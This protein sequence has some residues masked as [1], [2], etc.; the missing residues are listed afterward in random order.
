[1]CGEVLISCVSL[2]LISF[3]VLIPLL[4][5]FFL[6]ILPFLFIFHCTY[7]CSAIS[8]MSVLD[9]ATGDL[10]CSSVTEEDGKALAA[11]S[12]Y[13]LYAVTFCWNAKLVKVGVC[14]NEEV[15]LKYLKMRRAKKNICAWIVLHKQLPTSMIIRWYCCYL[16]LSETK[17]KTKVEQRRRQESPSDLVTLMWG[18]TGCIKFW[19]TS[20]QL[21]F[22]G[23]N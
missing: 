15:C 10:D 14:L 17:T 19:G 21:A 5:P 20:H 9:L 13:C 6:S 8:E 23:E 18:L 1:M 2:I 12:E 3:T 7:S 11:V 22:S 16:V 4:S